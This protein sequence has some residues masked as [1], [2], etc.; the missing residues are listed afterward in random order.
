MVKEII[1]HFYPVLMMLNC[2]LFVLAILFAPQESEKRD[3]FERVA[4]LFVPILNTDEIKN[5]GL[6]YM[7]RL[8]SDYVPI[9]KYAAGAQST[10]SNVCFK[11]LLEIRKE[12][13]SVVSGSKEDTFAIYLMDIR[14][15]EGNSVM[16][17]MA[18]TEMANGKE[19]PAA[20]VYVEEKDR[21]YCFERGIYV[22]QISVY[23]ENGGLE[24]YE[25]QLPI[26]G[27]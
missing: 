21:L 13:G 27:N 23:S 14:N 26:E 6:D 20:F 18:E 24:K 17:R 12:D 7:E 2:V 4:Q 9:V 19:A 5:D 11:N 25:F 22:V 8:I 1:R 3:A 10:G 15:Q 16:V